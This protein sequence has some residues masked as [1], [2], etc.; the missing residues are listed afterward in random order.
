[1]EDFEMDNMNLKEMTVAVFMGGSSSE[2]E[3][4]LKTGR[5]VMDSLS[6]Q[7]LK[8]V[9]VGE[10]G[11]VYKQA[12]ERVYDIAFI[13]LHG[14]EGED[15]TVQRF[16]EE[17]GIAYT[18][19]G[20][21]ACRLAMDKAAAKELFE[22]DGIPTP[23][24]FTLDGPKGS[25]E[26][27]SSHGWL[28]YPIVIKPSCEGSSVGLTIARSGK[29]FDDGLRAAFSLDRKVLVEE[30][31]PGDEATVGI[32]DGEPLPVV[33]IIPDGGVYDFK[34][35]YTAGRTQYE[36]PAA[37]SSDQCS[38]L[39]KTALKAHMVLGCEGATRVDFRVAPGFKP[40]VLEVN[41]IPGMTQT[42]LLPKSAAA[43]GMNFDELCMRI[44][45]AA[46]NRRKNIT[47]I[48]RGI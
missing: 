45:R 26:L 29:E 19:S 33:R 41:T 42:S 16:L 44:L 18:G 37:Y 23:R 9:T 11:D 4:S 39:Q 13:A 14:G 48:N 17:L 35:K 1:M 32:L 7:G 15:G 5:A 28:K 20:P 22:K 21:A 34:A 8:V 10:D 6:R 30:Y 27:M 2:R 38:I 46:I 25:E 24:S 40:S 36:V 3:I 47:T 31:I 43:A 12:R